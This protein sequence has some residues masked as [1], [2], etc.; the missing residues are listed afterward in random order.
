MKLSNQQE[1]SWRWR[2]RCNAWE[3]R[4]TGALWHACTGRPAAAP[5][6]AE[7]FFFFQYFWSMFRFFSSPSPGFITLQAA[8]GWFVASLQIPRFN[9]NN[10][11]T[12]IYNVTVSS[13]T[14]LSPHSPERCCSRLHFN[15]GITLFTTFC[16]I[17]KWLFC[18][19]VL[20]ISAA[21]LYFGD[22]NLPATVWVRSANPAAIRELVNRGSVSKMSVCNTHHYWTNYYNLSL[23]GL[24]HLICARYLNHLQAN[25]T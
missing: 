23:L 6:P 24:W 9:G 2:K 3:Q 16:F 12:W 8:L 17:L 10:S 22:I 14:S 1:M 21:W 13:P 5:T 4:L 18:C 20:V 11:S 7:G 15:P 25:V 19:K